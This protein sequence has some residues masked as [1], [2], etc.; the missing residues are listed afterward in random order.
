DLPHTIVKTMMRIDLPQPLI[1]GT[2]VKF[3]I[4]WDYQLI[5]ADLHDNAWRGG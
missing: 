1:S 3:S 5:D 2:S 4:R